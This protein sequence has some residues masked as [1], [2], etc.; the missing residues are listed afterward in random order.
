MGLGWWVGGGG[1]WWVVVGG[2]G[3]VVGVGGGGWV[4]WV[5]GGR[6]SFPQVGFSL[7]KAVVTE[8][9]K[10]HVLRSPFSGPEG[11]IL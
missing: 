9:I 7:T 11:A 2:G 1:W 4:V 10:G 3:W 6:F 5:G 8:P